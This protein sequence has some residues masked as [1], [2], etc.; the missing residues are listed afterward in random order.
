MRSWETGR[1]HNLRSDDTGAAAAER[2]W[3]RLLQPVPAMHFEDVSA[4]ELR[5]ERILDQEPLPLPA[6]PHGAYTSTG[7]MCTEARFAELD[8][9]PN[10]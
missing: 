1:P 6:P 3:W 5:R 4:A 9:F 10:L 8:V 2:P 7:L